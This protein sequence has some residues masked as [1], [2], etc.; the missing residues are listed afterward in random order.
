MLTGTVI[1][2]RVDA[3]G[4]RR[5]TFVGYRSA[6]KSR[7]FVPGCRNS[8]CRPTEQTLHAMPGSQA[9]APL[10]LQFSRPWSSMALN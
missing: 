2:V 4:R 7:F 6:R 3:S 5:S 9:S 8:R 1:E 10:R